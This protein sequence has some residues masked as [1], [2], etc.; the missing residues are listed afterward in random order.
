[1]ARFIFTLTLMFTCLMVQAQSAG[2]NLKNQLVHF[3]YNELKATLDYYK[4]FKEPRITYRWSTKLKREIVDNYTEEIIAFVERE[5]DADN[6]AISTLRTHHIKLIRK[7]SSLVFYKLVHLKN[8]KDSDGNW[9]PTEVR[10]AV[11]TADVSWQLLQQRYQQVYGVALN[12][13]ELFTTDLAYGKACG[14]IGGA[15]P[16]RI[17]LDELIAQRDTATLYQWLRSPAVELQLYAIDGFYQL[18][19]KGLF[20]RSNVRRLIAVVA[21]KRGEAYQCGGCI[22]MRLPI[23]LLVARIKGKYEDNDETPSLKH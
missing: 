15:P 10:V 17:K 4:D 23:R 6:A 7:D 22:Y 21:Q 5:Q 2:E 18:H 1:M 19:H 14:L 16:Y 13:H 3:D 20:M 9:V 8:V 11:D 12:Y